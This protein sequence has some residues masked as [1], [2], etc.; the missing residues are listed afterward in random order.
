MESTLNKQTLRELHSL[1]YEI[2]NE[3]KGLWADIGNLACDEE[4]LSGD[5]PLWRI[6]KRLDAIESKIGVTEKTEKLRGLLNS[7]STASRS[8][9]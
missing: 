4:Y 7:I 8:R 5:D 2:I 1:F 9:S 3:K 6:E